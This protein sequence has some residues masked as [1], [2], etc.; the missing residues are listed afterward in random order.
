[1]IRT[2]KVT[3]TNRDSSG[4]SWLVLMIS[5]LALGLSIAALSSSYEKDN[6]KNG[7]GNC[8]IDCFNQVADANRLALSDNTKQSTAGSNVWTNIA[9]NNNIH[10]S[11][12]WFHLPGSDS[13]TC[14]RSG[15]YNLF[16]SIQVETALP[17]SQ[18]ESSLLSSM[19]NNQTNS[20]KC[21]PCQLKFSMRG[22]QQHGGVGILEEID[23]SLTTS[24][25]ENLFLNKLFFINAT[26]GDVFRMQFKSTCP[27]LTIS[28][29]F[30]NTNVFNSFPTSATLSIF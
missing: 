22:T 27:Y 7:G 20:Q 11:S 16:F 1:M 17:L 23:A 9:Y 2:T 15:K 6:N 5:L 10:I 24:G 4:F 12:S 14:L 30:N 3:E 18:F 29:H 13:I 26:I 25:K 21:H 19:M 28:P 8:N